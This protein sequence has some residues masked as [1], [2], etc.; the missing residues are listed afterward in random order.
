MV[1]VI[2]FCHTPVGAT[3]AERHGAFDLLAHTVTVL[4]AAVALELALVWA[5]TGAAAATTASTTRAAMIEGFL[6]MRFLLPS[7]ARDCAVLEASAQQRGCR[8]ESARKRLPCEQSRNR[9]VASGRQPS[10]GFAR[11]SKLA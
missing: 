6:D 2:T 3:P 4:M 8:D 5:E 1:E 10:N 7:T 9:S 11:G